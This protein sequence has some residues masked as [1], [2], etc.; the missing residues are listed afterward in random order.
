MSL[1]EFAG[2]LL[3]AGTL[4]MGSSEARADESAE[5]PAL[6]E[7]W[8]M[9]FDVPYGTASEAQRLDIV[10]AQDSMEK[11]PAIVLIHGGGWYSGEKG[12]P[13]TFGMLAAFAKAGYI[14]LSIGYRL[15][16]EAPFPAAVEDCQEAVRWLRAHAPRYGVDTDRIGAMGASAGGHLSAML[17]VTRTTDG[18]ANSR[19]FP[20]QSCAIQAAVPVCAPFDLR[21]PLSNDPALKDDPAVV[22]FLGGTVTEK[23]RTARRAS[24]IAYVRNDLPPMLIIHGAADERVL[25]SQSTAMAQAL[26]YAG[27]PHELILVKNGSHGMGI[28]RQED[29]FA[30]VLAF[31]ERTL[32]GPPEPGSGR[33]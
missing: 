25:P 24:P 2:A 7:G 31:F 30:H 26:K 1:L 14:A 3:L 12:G 10:H 11:L 28:A 27:A 6:P 9:E 20:H 17:A 5:A 23:P 15:S 4:W 21:V 32:K 8:V 19:R 22:Q 18:F 16:D 29:V 33:E 13:K